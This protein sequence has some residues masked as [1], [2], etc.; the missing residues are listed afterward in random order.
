MIGS[1]R[2][3][4][5]KR[6]IT[7]LPGLMAA[8]GFSEG[9][10]G[11]TADSS[12]NGHTLTGT[13]WVASAK[14]G[15]GAGSTSLSWV[16]STNGIGS[17]T[18][19]AQSTMCAWFNV[20]TLPFTTGIYVGILSSDLANVNL[21]YSLSGSEVLVDF[22]AGTGITLNA[23]STTPL[24]TPTFVAVVNNGNTSTLYLGTSSSNLAQ[25]GTDN[26]IVT[27]A[28]IDFTQK[29]WCVGAPADASTGAGDW[30]DEI[31][32]FNYALTLAELKTW[33]GTPVS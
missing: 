31:R 8:Y 32:V 5:A 24:D 14:N 2:S 26:P 21:E 22:Y 33:M 18:A 20:H 17:G 13:G 4:F 11:T 29:D 28:G 6:P 23:T 27:N 7:L 25:A 1:A 16:A 12:G 19:N 15:S 9:S 3:G 30:I 10:G